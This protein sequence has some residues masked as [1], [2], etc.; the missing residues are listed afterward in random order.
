[1]GDKGGSP[2]PKKYPPT[3]EDNDLW[4]Q[5]LT[6]CESGLKELLPKNLTTGFIEVQ[7]KLTLNKRLSDSWAKPHVDAYL[8]SCSVRECQIQTLEGMVEK[9]N[10][11]QCVPDHT[12]ILPKVWT[13][14]NCFIRLVFPDLPMHWIGGIISDVMAIIHYVFMRNKRISMYVV[15]ENAVIIDI[16]SFHLDWCKVKNFPR[17]PGCTR[18]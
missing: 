11:G 15:F 2:A 1:M 4:I 10:K 12:E 16:E 9:V 7:L 6:G 17:L 14:I 8:T 3:S 18:I 5:E 13:I